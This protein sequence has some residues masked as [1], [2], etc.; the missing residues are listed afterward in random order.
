VNLALVRQE[1]NPY[2]GAER[3]LE[4]AIEALRGRGA[5]VTIITRR[6]PAGN[7]VRALICNP[8]YV[9][10]LMRDWGFARAVRNVVTAGHFDLVQSHER[11]VGCDIFRAGDGVHAEWLRQRA[12]VM[13]AAGRLRLALNPYHAYMKA[14]ERAMFQS[15]KLRMVICNSQMVKEEI[16][17]QFDVPE[18]K[19][20]VIYNGVDTA[21]FNPQL[22][23]L[24]RA[25]VRAALGWSD[26]DVVL[27]LVGS[28]FERKGVGAA[29]E[30]LRQLPARVRL[31]VVGKDKHVEAYRAR[32]RQA[33]LAGRVEFVGG[34][35]DVL[36][37]Y[38][39]ADIFVMPA[40]YEPLGNVVLEALACGVPAVTSTKCG[41][42]E[43]ITNGREGYVTDALDIAAI[44]A[45]LTALM[46][47]AHR[48]ACADA[49]RRQAERY[50]WQSMARDFDD[51][52]RNLLSSAVPSASVQPAA[53]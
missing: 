16:R 22:R 24:H 46:D 41:S 30:A 12:R 5:D 8:F 21:K 15:P 51:L 27:L 9:G 4:R 3:F 26:D 25:P 44:V 31:L 33:G 28:G 1:Y 34:Q 40:L 37:Y 36:P 17:T 18:H 23:A 47:P 13:G 20:Q 42:R 38:G 19:L 53:R 7:S 49:A 43:F 6:W 14:T 50:T 35:K 39:A 45:A 11:I 10:S 32:A 29:I 52:Y 48:Q 2:G